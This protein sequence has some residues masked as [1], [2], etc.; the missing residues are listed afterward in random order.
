MNRMVEVIH[1]NKVKSSR[2]KYVVSGNTD[3]IE[4]KHVLFGDINCTN[5]FQKTSKKKDSTT[6]ECIFISNSTH[7]EIMEDIMRRDRL[8]YNEDVVDEDEE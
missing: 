8:N 1:C 5:F 3:V 7:D 2:R 4:L 6:F